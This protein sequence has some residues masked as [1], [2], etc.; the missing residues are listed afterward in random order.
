MLSYILFPTRRYTN[1][2]LYFLILLIFSG[3]G[4]LERKNNRPPGVLSVIT[5]PYRAARWVYH[6]EPVFIPEV[7]ADS[8]AYYYGSRIQRTMSLLATSNPKKPN[9]VKILF[10]GQSIIAG[11]DT[12]AIIEKLNERFPDAQIEYKNSAIGGFIAPRLVR[13]ATHDLYPYYPDLVVFHVYKG[14]DSGA[15][16]EIIRAIRSKT[17][18]D[19]MLLN[20]HIAWHSNPDSLAIKTKD[21][22]YASDHIRY[23]AQK[24]GCELVD[25]RKSWMKFLDKHDSYAVNNLMGDEVHSNVH[26]NKKGNAIIE[27]LI[28]RHF[29]FNPISNAQFNR[30]WFNQVRSYN[31]KQGLV[32]PDDDHLSLNGQIGINK[33]YVTLD[34][35]VVEMDFVGNRV[36]LIS[37]KVDSLK[38]A[39][40]E[41]YIDG[42][43]PSEFDQLYVA[44][45]PS[46]S[47]NHWSPALK[48]V[49]LRENISEEK[50]VLRITKIN[51]E[52]RYLE[53]EL[54]GSQ[55]GFDGRGNNMS[56]FT[57][58]SSQI[59]LHPEDFFL[60]DADEYT[61]SKTDRGFE[62]HWSV[63]P[64]H[65]DQITMELSTKRYLLAQ[66][67]PNERHTLT[68]VHTGEK[69]SF[70]I[71]EIVV[72]E[73]PL[74]W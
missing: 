33:G 44:T 51:H 73:P 65:K 28:M 40:I 2:G 56:R 55:T 38:G 21:D 59:I 23:L 34:S 61:G 4:L 68:L 60:F 52:Q 1:F 18:S 58:N 31:L 62:I 9:Q 66:G 48:H 19:I 64:K 54:Y 39:Q 63:I 49:E 27:E 16:E 13:T 67:L 3:G 53:F 72:Y 29:R 20:H 45:R 25:I 14:E 71:K 36:E 69:K 5:L 41:V 24:Y 43:K 32:N 37:K 7:P 70:P 10:Y 26:P 42:K 8:M 47:L 15:L 17:T 50:W 57:S 30:G 74:K 11:L 22:T 35:A 46:R 12:E 6:E